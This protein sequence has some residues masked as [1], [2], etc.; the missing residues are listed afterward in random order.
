[1]ISDVPCSENVTRT[2]LSEAWSYTTWTPMRSP[3]W[4][5]I[6]TD[7]PTL[8][9]NRTQYSMFTRFTA[10]TC[11]VTFAR[12][13][14]RAYNPSPASAC[15]HGSPYWALCVSSIFNRQLKPVGE[16]GS[17]FVRF[18]QF[19]AWLAPLPASPPN[20]TT[21]VLPFIRVEFAYK[22]CH[23]TGRDS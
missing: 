21:T 15:G 11:V 1:M 7:G 5:S 2:N 13:V 19:S 9:P 10:G 14:A 20:G 18:E 4:S 17:P 23:V 12:Y 16:F 22:Y 6:P 8:N 3:W